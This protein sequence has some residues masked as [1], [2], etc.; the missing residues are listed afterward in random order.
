MA[1]KKDRK[2]VELEEVV[3]E[4]TAGH[5]L[6]RYNE[7]DTEGKVYLSSNE[8]RVLK[9]F[10]EEFDFSRIEKVEKVR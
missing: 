7:E 8:A 9:K 2:K 6:I 3:F 5:I 1:K 4:E 10:L